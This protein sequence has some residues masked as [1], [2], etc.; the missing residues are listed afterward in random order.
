MKSLKPIDL[1]YRRKKGCLFGLNGRKIK[2]K[3]DIHGLV[4]IPMPMVQNGAAGQHD[5]PKSEGRLRRGW[6]D[7]LKHIYGVDKIEH[8]NLVVLQF[9]TDGWNLWR[10]C[11][12]FQL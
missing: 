2:E 5:R 8:S 10:N 12:A 7:N 11:T 1:V 3:T 4:L 9:I 6:S